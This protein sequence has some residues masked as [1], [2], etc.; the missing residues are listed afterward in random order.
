MKKEAMLYEK[1]K[2]DSVHCFLCSH[3]C[4][5]D[6]HDFGFCKVRENIDQTL[7]T[8]VYGV[9]IA[10]HV[11]PIEK[12]PLYHF[13]P[14]TSSFS[15]GTVGCNF[16]CGFCQNW[17]ISQAAEQA[18]DE[19][20]YGFSLPPEEVVA[21]A[22]AGDCRSIAYTY[23][24]PTIFFEYA[25]DT[26]RLA[27][28]RG[29]RNIFVTNGFMT[30]KALRTIAPSLDAANVDLKAWQE[31]YYRD[32][33]MG[34]MKPVLNTIRLMKELGIWVEIT[35][36]LIPGENDFPEDI[37]GIASFLAEIDVNIPW[38]ISAF[39]PTYRFTDRR[40]T[41]IGSLE[42]AR[43]IGREEG[44]RYIYL[45]NVPAE[46]STV[47]PNCGMAVI[48]RRGRGVEIAELRGNQCAACGETIPGVW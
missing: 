37:R 9:S 3:H 41:E 34:R 42:E 28:E 45:G 44:L 13:L 5:I 8:H 18:R 43:R 19:A 31:K 36:L 21:Q 1:L 23:T 14:G 33:C 7:Y 48:R 39:H 47:C 11:D 30:D 20:D 15:I 10:R 12:K 32:I 38:H 17:Q 25:Y 4:R 6:N 40:P 35:T 46:N 27:R 26:S 2:G 22:M 29:L 16:H 24:E